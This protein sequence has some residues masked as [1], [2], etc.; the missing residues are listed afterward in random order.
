MLGKGVNE[1][2]A[3]RKKNGNFK[4]FFKKI[5]KRRILFFLPLA[6]TKLSHMSF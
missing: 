1:I 3:S 2:G 6:A 4:G 5:S